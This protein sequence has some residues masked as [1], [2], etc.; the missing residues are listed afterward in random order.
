MSTADP[1]NDSRVTAIVAAAVV[2]E[3]ASRADDELSPATIEELAVASCTALPEAPAESAEAAVAIDAATAAVSSTEP[4][5]SAVSAVD[6]D[7][8]MSDE[9]ASPFVVASESAADDVTRA[10][11]VAFDGPVVVSGDAIDAVTAALLPA[12]VV[13]NTVSTLVSAGAYCPSLVPIPADEPAMT[14]V[15]ADSTVEDSYTTPLES[16][17]AVEPDAAVIDAPV[18]TLGED[19]MVDAD[20]SVESASSMMDAGPLVERGDAMAAVAV[21]ESAATVTGSDVIV[22]V[23]RDARTPF[24]VTSVVSSEVTG[25]VLALVTVASSATYPVSSAEVTVL[26]AV[27]ISDR[28]PTRGDATSISAMDGVVA[29]PPSAVESDVLPSADG[30]APAP[31]AESVARPALPPTYGEALDCVVDA[32]VMRYPATSLT[33]GD[34]SAAVS[35]LTSSTNVVSA[36]T[37]LVAVVRV[38]RPEALAS[39]AEVSLDFSGTAV[40]VVTTAPSVALDHSP[41]PNVVVCDEVVAAPPSAR[42]SSDTSTIVEVDALMD[43]ESPADAPSVESATL[44]ADADRVAESA[45]DESV[46]GDVLVAEVSASVPALREDAVSIASSVSVDASESDA[47]SGT[48]DSAFTSSGDATASESVGASVTSVVASG[49]N[50]SAAA[51]Y[52]DASVTDEDS[53]SPA[54][55]S[56][57]VGA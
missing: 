6:S 23:S 22:V 12:E 31:V 42:A 14:D 51:E 9:T 11:V 52:I 17:S 47:S 18:D 7:D 45:A 2:G 40:S 37:P 43:A 15:L 49:V 3:A 36:V 48:N 55:V 28:S 1:T 50:T 4:Y 30:V 57:L 8:A 41:V 35:V 56:M 10:S 38:I 44:D 27:V 21:G 33:T 13:G 34:A 20:A 46:E 5:P 16:A 54:I 39:F 53:S 19:V 32:P 29:A 26:S 24:S 25:A